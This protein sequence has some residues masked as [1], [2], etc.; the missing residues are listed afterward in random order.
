VAFVLLPLILQGSALGGDWP[1]FRGPNGDGISSLT[2][3]RKD[4]DKTPPKELWKMDLA[5][6]MGYTGPAVADGKLYICDRDNAKDEGLV[7]ALDPATGKQ[8]WRTA[9]PDTKVPDDNRKCFV[10]GTPLVYDGKVYVF[11][12]VAHAFC[13][14]AKTGERI[15][16]RALVEDYPNP[17][18]P[19]FGFA[20]SPVADGQNIIFLPGGKDNASIV[21]LDKDTGKTLWQSGKSKVSYASPVVATLNGRKQILAFVGPGLFGYDPAT[22]KEFW[23]LPWP[24]LYDDKKG[25]TPVV[26]GDRIFVATTEGGETGLV[27]V[28]DDKPT[29]VWKYK[30]VQNHFPTA[31]Y[32][33][34]RIYCGNDPSELVCIEPA[35]GKILWKQSVNDFTSVVGVDDTII[36]LGGGGRSAGGQL[37][38]ID[39]TVPEYKEICRVNPVLFSTPGV[40]MFWTAPIIA[41]GRLFVRNFKELR[42]FDLK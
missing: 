7:L 21:A 35:T 41:D 40:S 32:Y 38:M 14:N 33:H 30:D 17:D 19:D 3:I 12:R 34:G 31:V 26:V 37:V 39:A 11:S 16:D 36:A 27:D 24:T 22:G 13:L 18:K 10:W 8:I 4:W 28:K 15:W 9:V 5:D 20:S 29:V 42:C 25:P 2:G 6:P 23:N 1:C